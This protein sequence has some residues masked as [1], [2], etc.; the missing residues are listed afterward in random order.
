MN[1]LLI[2]LNLVKRTLRNRKELVAL[3]VLPI[4]VIGVIAYFLS[5]DDQKI[6]R[7]G[8]INSDQ[9]VLGSRLVDHL[10]YED[11]LMVGLP[12]SDY[13]E[14]LANNQ[15][16]SVLVIPANF[17]N[18]IETG[19]KTNL[20]VYTLRDGLEPQQVKQSANQY[21]QTLYRAE[22]LAEEL[23]ETTQAPSQDKSTTF[24]A[25]LDSA[26]N[27]LMGLTSTSAGQSSY[28]QGF[29]QTI[30]FSIL[31][32][33][34]LVFTSMG[35]IMEDKKNFTLARMYVSAI[36]EWEI[37]IGNL[38]GCLALAILQLIPITLLLKF[39]FAIPWG[40]TL[41][42]LFLLLLFFQLATI[43]LGI[44]L[45]GIIK[46]NFNPAV[47]SATV[48]IPTSIIGGAFIP[49]SM[50]PSIL[51]TISWAVP[52]KWVM[53]GIEKLLEEANL[54]AITPNLGILL[55]FALAF[56]T[57]GLKSIRPLQDG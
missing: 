31:F 41:I 15:V 19:R 38:L 56:A 12:G 16:D 53:N 37:I 11:F 49:E 2:A 28:P 57:F 29:Q 27:G 46:N 52:Q 50:M 22:E 18:D 4:I 34:I 6:I 35:T 55:L 25:L 45:S 20:E 33:M 39:M 7:V 10:Q 26:N 42:G 14:E 48:I 21:T 47:V 43:G 24:T 9:G 13:Q 51:N 32:M 36:R 8:Y 17:S 3:L 1:S 54:A 23:A 30:G 5:Q 44:G 40:E